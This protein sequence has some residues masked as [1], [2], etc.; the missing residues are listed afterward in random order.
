M[1]PQNK[2]RKLARKKTLRAR[3]LS[4]SFLLIILPLLVTSVLLYKSSCDMVLQ[5]AESALQASSEEGRR[6]LHNELNAA[7]NTVSTVAEHLEIQ[8]IQSR[9]LSQ[10]YSLEDQLS[11]FQYI[12]DF[13]TMLKQSPSIYQVRMTVSDGL[14]YS[15]SP[16]FVP[17]EEGLSLYASALSKMSAG[18]TVAF[19]NSAVEAPVFGQ[20]SVNV[21]S[22]LMPIQNI[23]NYQETIGFAIAN[24]QLSA[25]QALLVNTCPTEDTSCLLVDAQGNIIAQKNP[26]DL[27]LEALTSAIGPSSRVDT[28]ESN[29]TNSY[30]YA[31]QQDSIYG[32]KL[33]YLQPIAPVVEKNTQ[34]FFM[35]VILLLSLSS[36]TLLL[37]SFLYRSLIFRIKNI[38][39]TM[40]SVE[41]GKLDLFLPVKQRDEI[42]EIEES[43]NKMIEKLKLSL[44][45]TK[46]L[47]D[48]LN[49]AEMDALMARINPHFLYNTL[50]TL[51]WT[52]LD[53]KA[54][55]I[56]KML[57]ALSKYYKVCLQNNR[58]EFT[59]SEEILHA[60]LYVEIHNMRYEKPIYFTWDVPESLMEK[61]IPNMVIQ[62]IIENSVIHGILEKPEKTG[63]ITLTVKEMETHLVISVW[64]DGVGLNPE[65]MAKSIQEQNHTESS[66]GLHNIY[67]RLRLKYGQAFSLQ[68]ESAPGRGTTVRISIPFTT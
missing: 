43:Y 66:Y 65:A 21:V 16:L 52:A 39:S 18:Q 23:N 22:C 61:K 36:V 12:T 46:R 9:G 53:Y 34:S 32:W 2:P 41:S 45:E 19:C 14:I 48:Q 7:Y 51:S 50:N 31:Y 8:N 11:D 42:G 55:D 15:N 30:I 38:V 24:I 17:K 26:F 63:K 62:P 64:D 35:I 60:K 28:V 68:F 56:S 67:E 1:A 13:F 4:V 54:Y 33:Y 20:K 47:S 25:F 10:N 29:W 37:G 5:T 6:L 59:I 44:E 40:H 49:A 58:P 27:D 3:L 57:V